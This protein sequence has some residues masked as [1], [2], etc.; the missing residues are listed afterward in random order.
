MLNSEQAKEIR[1]RRRKY[2]KRKTTICFSIEDVA[3]LTGLSK[4][5]LSTMISAGSF[6][7]KDLAGFVE[8]IYFYLLK[9][10]IKDEKTTM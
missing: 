2:P 3:N 4:R 7:P 8:F 5:T 6:N 1:K 9:Q 10:K